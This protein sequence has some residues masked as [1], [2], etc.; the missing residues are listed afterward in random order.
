MLAPDVAIALGKAQHKGGTVAARSRREGLFVSVADTNIIPNPNDL[1]NVTKSHK[2]GQGPLGQI[3]LEQLNGGG[4]SITGHF[5]RVSVA[6]A[7]TEPSG[8]R[9]CSVAH[10][11]GL[12]L[13]VFIVVVVGC[14][15]A[16]A[17]VLLKS[18]PF[19]LHTTHEQSSKRER[20]GL[21]TSFVHFLSLSFPPPIYPVRAPVHVV[22]AHS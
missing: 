4:S 15:F 6:V 8:E 2:V 5:L 16:G 19:V 1:V 10:L 18:H 20:A 7:R 22:E 11:A 3:L 9:C 17:A 14:V 21:K 12:P 13:Q